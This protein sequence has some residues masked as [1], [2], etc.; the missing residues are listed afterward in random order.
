MSLSYDDNAQWVKIPHFLRIGSERIPD[1]LCHNLKRLI[2]A[3][4]DFLGFLIHCVMQHSPEGKFC[5][6]IMHLLGDFAT[7]CSHFLHI[8]RDA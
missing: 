1:L 4:C 3:K 6:R 2:S 8:N 5:H 7:V